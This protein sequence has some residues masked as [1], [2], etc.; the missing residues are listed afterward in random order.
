MKLKDLIGKKII[1]IRPITAAERE[2]EGWDNDHSATSVLELD[3]GTIIYPS[4]D[5]EGNG[6]GTLFGKTKDGTTFY[7]YD[8]DIVE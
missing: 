1:R 6:A 3:D 2:S 5:D 4:Q 7:C 8:K